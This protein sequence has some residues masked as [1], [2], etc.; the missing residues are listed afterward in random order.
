MAEEHA[1]SS[2]L[3]E[4]CLPGA[5]IRMYRK[6][7]TMESLTMGFHLEAPVLQQCTLL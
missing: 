2:G 5:L 6:G 4:I 7:P 1:G 3:S